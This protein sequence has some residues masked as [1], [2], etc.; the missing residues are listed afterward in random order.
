MVRVTEVGAAGKRRHER[1]PSF[2]KAE[3]NGQPISVLDVSVGGVGG[4]IELRGDSDS[5]PESGEMAT[6]V[7]QPD[8]DQPVV[9]T[10]ELIYVDRDSNLFGA[11]IIEMG[12]DQCQIMK[13]LSVGRSL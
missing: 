9:L 6:I 12:D 11:Q 7:L 8:G 5:I 1:R 3:P 13:W 10:V 2:I 4:T